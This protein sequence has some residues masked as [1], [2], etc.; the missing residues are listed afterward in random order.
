MKRREIIEFITNWLRSYLEESQANGFVIGV[1]GGID[2]AVCSTLAA[3]TGLPLLCIEMPIHQS[4]GQVPTSRNQIAFL[5]E[6]FPNTRSHEV[7][8]TPMFE[9]LIKALPEAEEMG[10]KE[11]SLTN[12][13]ARLRMTTLYYF[14]GL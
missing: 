4:L 12:V 9:E 13:R 2:S 6:N 5:K 1:S 10:K 11:M 14:S 8:L 7:D 3:R